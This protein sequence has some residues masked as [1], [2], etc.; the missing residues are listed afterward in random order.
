MLPQTILVTGATDGIGKQTALELACM[1]AHVIVHGR[2]LARAHAAVDDIRRAVERTCG[3]PQLDIVLADFS[4][5]E[6][7]RQM[8]A[9]VWERFPRLDVLINNAGV[10]M[11]R[12]QLTPQGLEHTFVI[13]HLAHFLLTHLLLDLLKRSAPARIINVSSNT[14][15]W[16]TDVDF[17]NLQGE[18]HFDGDDAY[19]LS[20][21]ANI[22]FTYDLAER[23]QGSGVTV[24]A[25]HPGV[26]DTKLLRAGFVA[27]GSDVGEGAETSV[28]LAYA[29]QVEGVSGK[30]FVRKQP[31]GTSTLSRD[32][33]LRRRF[34]QV[35][36]ELAGLS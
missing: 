28:Y 35:S 34:W 1:G 3:D 21:L 5:L 31:T 25:L 36:E 11:K 30:Y 18:H 4:S 33:E 13:N 29:E 9:Q 8:A 14:Y 26:I 24:N 6:Q 23:L 22:W 19:A 12:R 10:F 2:S 32:R 20:K 27:Q 16:V 7:V 15:Q 17:D